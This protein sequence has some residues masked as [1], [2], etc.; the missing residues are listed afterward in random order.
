MMITFTSI[1]IL[2]D[3]SEGESVV[4]KANWYLF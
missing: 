1:G 2:V 3:E 4:I